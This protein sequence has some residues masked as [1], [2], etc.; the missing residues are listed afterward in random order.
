MPNAGRHSLLALNAA[1]FWR[2]ILYSAFFENGRLS[3]V[4]DVAAI[5]VFCAHARGGLFY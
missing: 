2:L 3:L 4:A 5:A 1:L